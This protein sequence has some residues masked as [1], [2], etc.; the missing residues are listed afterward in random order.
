M[1]TKVRVKRNHSHEMETDGNHI[2]GV[3]NLKSSTGNFKCNK[4]VHTSP[5]M[6]LPDEGMNKMGKAQVA[7][8]EKKPTVEKL[9]RQIIG[10]RSIV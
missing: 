6:F 1:I 5:T 2:K 3:K 8:L 9:N 4:K 10:R 7:L